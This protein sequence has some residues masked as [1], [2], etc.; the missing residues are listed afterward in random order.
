ML[1][2]RRPI[3]RV[4]LVLALGLY[5]C[6]TSEQSSQLGVFTVAV[7]GEQVFVGRSRPNG[8]DSTFEVES[9]ADPRIVCHGRVR[10][11]SS[12]TSIAILP[13]KGRGTFDCSNGEHG[14][15][16]IRVEGR[17]VGS[18]EGDS[19]FGPVKVLFGYSLLE[20]NNRLMLPGR[21]L[22]LDDGKIGVLETAQ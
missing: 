22:V 4:A 9:L 14:M 7:A 15:L 6:A 19:S 11:S 17:N 10:Y 8:A 20:V 12:P 16:K 2:V 1:A 18:G 3:V 5:G 21:K 13:P